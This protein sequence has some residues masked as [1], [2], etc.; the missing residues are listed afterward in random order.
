MT[1]SLRGSWTL[2]LV[3]DPSHMEVGAEVG[4]ERGRLGSGGG[5]TKAV[6]RG[7]EVEAGTGGLGRPGEQAG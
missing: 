3:V 4:A 5:I 6:G 7:W 1:S 2:V